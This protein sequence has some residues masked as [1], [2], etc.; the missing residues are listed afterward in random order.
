[1]HSPGRIPPRKS[2]LTGLIKRMNKKFIWFWLTYTILLAVI[3]L[4]I[5][6][7]NRDLSLIFGF[8]ALFGL[9]MIVEIVRKHKDFELNDNILVIKQSFKQDIKLDLT[10]LTRWTEKTFHFRGQQKRILILVTQERKTI[11]VTDKD[12][13]ME[14]E[15]L[16]HH[17]RVN[18]VDKRG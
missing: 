16:F 13:L 2:R 15:K 12:D 7:Q 10:G 9:Y 5:F 14:F 4:K 3:A 6:S 1:M 18:H 17:L 8:S 11:E